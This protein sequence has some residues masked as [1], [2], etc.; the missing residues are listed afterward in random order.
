[1]ESHRR[2]LV[3]YRRCIFRVFEINVL[4]GESSPPLTQ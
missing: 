2:I 1:M 4:G 3:D